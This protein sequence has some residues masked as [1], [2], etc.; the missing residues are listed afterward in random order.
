MKAPAPRISAGRPLR[1]DRG[2]SALR[3]LYCIYQGGLV[4]LDA[5]QDMLRILDGI[6]HRLLHHHMLP[7]LQSANKGL[8]VQGVRG[9]DGDETDIFPLRPGRIWDDGGGTNLYPSK[10][11][12][13]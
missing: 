10:Q 8:P 9:M 4:I 5:I 13:V 6:G 2:R 3:A 12:V 11:S 7:G 1:K